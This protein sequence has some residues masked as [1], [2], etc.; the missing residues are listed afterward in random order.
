MA[1]VAGTGVISMELDTEGAP[2]E[3]TQ[4]GEVE[5]F[6]GGILTAAQERLRAA[7]V[8]EQVRLLELGLTRMAASM[9]V[10]LEHTYRSLAAL[11]PNPFRS[12]F[13]VKPIT[14]EADRRAEAYLASLLTPGEQRALEA[15]KVVP[16]L[17]AETGDLWLVSRRYAYNLLRYER[18]S[19]PPFPA[20][21]PTL[22]CSSPTRSIPW[23]DLVAS[24]VLMLR[25]P[26]RELLR[27][28]NRFASTHSISAP[29]DGEGEA[30]RKLYRK[31]R[32]LARCR[33][34]D[35][36]L[37]RRTLKAAERLPALA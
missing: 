1:Q 25:G 28:A 30:E 21:S 12:A 19:P 11:Y 5:Q 24:L 18:S 17:G 33:C 6:E 26:E 32:A 7:E 16:V 15:L 14:P 23:A 4:I 35:E 13:R 2:G 31:L 29:L 20:G 37:L 22:Y 8:R 9:T 27:V 10:N 3:Y 36:R 34:R